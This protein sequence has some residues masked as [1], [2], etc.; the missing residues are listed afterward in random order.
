[1]LDDIYTSDDFSALPEAVFAVRYLVKGVDIIPDKT[2]E[3][4]SDD[5]AVLREVLAGHEVEFRNYCS[6][7]NLTFEQLLPGS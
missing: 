1:M 4:Y 7:N 5:A 6:K 2:E 3:G